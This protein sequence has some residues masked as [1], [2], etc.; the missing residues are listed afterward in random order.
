MDIPPL[1]ILVVSNYFNDPNSGAGG[2]V[3]ATNVAFRELGHEVDEIWA[4]QLGPRRIAHGNLH[5]L[6][7]Q[8][9]AYRREVLKAVAK[10]TYDVIMMSQPQACLAARALRN[11]NF[12]GA[13][14]SRSHGLELRV[15]ESLPHWH[16]KLKV[17][18]SRFPMSLGTPLIRKLLQRQWT[19]T[20]KYV[21][22]VVVPCEMD[23]DFLLQ[24][25]S[26]LPEFVQTIHHGVSASILSVPTQPMT[27]ARQLAIL[28][29]GQFAFFKG[30]HLVANI[31][32]RVFDQF[33]NVHLTWVTSAQGCQQAPSLIDTKHRH[34]VKFV[35][36]GTQDE[37]LHIFDDHGLF[38]FPSLCEG[39]AK[40]CLEAMARGLCVIGSDDSG[41]RDY[42]ENNVNGYLCPV[43]GVDEFA[44]AISVA[45]CAN[46]ISHL[47]RAAA[48]YGQSKTWQRCALKLQTLFTSVLSTKRH[49]S[50]KRT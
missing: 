4:N 39:A 3:C 12:T 17:P 34:R 23:R 48:Q 26:V 31:I 43:G 7:E 16:K 32:N 5:S 11:A 25:Y 18:A 6:I 20:I 38:L 45:I 47:S 2:T 13:I 36:W 14:V 49:S 1:R 30:P 22:R 28:H 10:K 24:K 33:Q 8:P 29:V 42:I 15:D 46:D 37:L 19:N 50:T 40:S 21:D 27:R 44:D 35:S 41:M 9:R